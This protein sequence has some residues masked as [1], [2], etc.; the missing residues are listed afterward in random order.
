M[1]VQ[2]RRE[3]FI[4]YQL[5][6]IDAPSAQAAVQA[7][8]A[9]LREQH[10]QLQMRLLRRFEEGDDGRQTWMEIYSTD[11]MHDPAGITVELQ[12]EIEARAGALLTLLA[13]P[14]HIEV[15]TACVS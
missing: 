6:S 9:Q 14:R 7:L 13:G 4:Y 3:L 10:P 2:P 12:A 8:Q 1:S 15:F 5:R 11:P